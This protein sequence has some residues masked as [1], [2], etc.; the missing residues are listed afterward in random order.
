[1]AGSGIRDTPTPLSG[2]GRRCPIC[3]KSSD[4]RRRPFC[5]ARCADIDLGRWLKG[6]YRIET[7]EPPDDD[8]E[9]GER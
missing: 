8:A 3:G 9:T 6:N 4:P 5:S 1:M 7:E 2:G